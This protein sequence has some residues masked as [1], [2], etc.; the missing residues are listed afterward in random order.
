MALFEWSEDYS[1]DV[2]KFD[3]QHKNM[4]EILNDLHGAMKEGKSKEKLED[5]LQRLE[6][7]TSY[8]FGDE[9]KYMSKYD[10]PEMDEHEEQHENFV[11]KVKEFREKHHQGKMTVSMEM[12]DF[13][14]DWLKNHIKGTDMK[15]SEFFQDKDIE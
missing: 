1:V 14:K 12:M 3:E 10:Y 13:L 7:Y 6:D 5:I 15:Y 2:E 4:V 11:E 8:H 9:E